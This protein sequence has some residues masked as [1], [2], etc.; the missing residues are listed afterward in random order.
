MENKKLDQLFTDKLGGMEIIP[1]ASAQEVFARKV[2]LIKQ[3][4]LMRRLGIAASISLLFIAGI[5]AFWPGKAEKVDLSHEGSLIPDHSMNIADSKDV[6]VPVM[7]S[8]AEDVLADGEF[9]LDSNP[10]LGI[11]THEDAES[12]VASEQDPVPERL[13]EQSEAMAALDGRNTGAIAQVNATEV[14]S[15]EQAK[16][17]V[18]IEYVIEDQAKE[19]QSPAKQYEPVKITIEY[20]ASG[21]NPDLGRAN[22]K[23]TETDRKQFYTKLDNMKSVDEVLGDIRTYKDRLFALDFKK[24]NKV[25]D[26]EKSEE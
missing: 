7:S 11:K 23:Q 18:Y 12:F 24:E 5:Y 25:K 1:S 4:I 20:I 21:K 6:P 8:E 19:G 26:E 10:E 17:G 9:V 16:E 13:P 3:R 14:M 22:G 15:S 2:G